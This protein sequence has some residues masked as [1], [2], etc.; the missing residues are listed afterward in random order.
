MR[1]SPYRAIASRFGALKNGS[2]SSAAGVDA[3]ANRVHVRVPGRVRRRN[4]GVKNGAPLC[5]GTHTAQGRDAGS[6]ARD[7]GMQMAQSTSFKK[8]SHSAGVAWPACRV[9]SFLRH[10]ATFGRATALRVNHARA[11]AVPRAHSYSRPLRL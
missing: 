1:A 5:I 6:D 10:C 9:V 2:R 3:G 8:P 11:V 7:A 4:L